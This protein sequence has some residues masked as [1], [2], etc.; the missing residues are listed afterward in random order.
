MLPRAWYERVLQVVCPFVR[1]R[2]FCWPLGEG[3]LLSSFFLRTFVVVFLQNRIRATFVQRD[4]FAL[5]NIFIM[6]P[7]RVSFRPVTLRFQQ[8]AGTSRGIYTERRLWYVELRGNT[9]GRQLFGIGECAPLV[10]LSCDDVPDYEKRL[11]SACRILAATGEIP[12][13]LL[14]NYPSILMGLETAV[15]SYEACLRRGNPFALYDT[16]FSRG[17]EG[18]A[19]NG[20]VWMGSYDEMFA[21][22]EEKLDAG[23]RCVKLKIGAIDFERELD[24]LRTL[25]RRYS[26]QQ[27]EIRVDANGAF[28]PREVRDRLHCLADFELHS[29]EQPI[30]PGLWSEMGRLCRESPLPIALDEE[31]IGVNSIE[32]RRRLLD[33]IQP[34]YIIL[35]PTLHGGFSGAEEWGRLADERGIGHWVT[36]ALE[37]NIG[38]NAIAQ[39]CSVHYQGARE[40]TQGLGTGQLFIDNYE[41]ITLCVEQGLLWTGDKDTRAFLRA[42][43]LFKSEWESAT[44]TMEVITSGSTGSPQLL[45]VEKSRME[46][47]ARRT[48]RFLGLQEGATALLCLPLKYIAGKMMVVRALVGKLRLLCVAPC[49]HPLRHVVVPPDFIALTPMQALASLRTEGERELLE[50]AR[51][52]IIGG[53]AISPEL[54]SAVRTCRGKVYSTYGMTETLSH[55]ALRRLNGEHP[56]EGYTPLEGVALSLTSEECLV[57]N[58]PEVCS[59]RLVTRDR[60]QL[61]ADGT[62]RLLGRIDNVVCS[63]GLKLQLEMLEEK[64]L[65]LPF[66]FMLTAVPDAMLGEALVLLHEPTVIKVEKI[67]RQRL[68]RHEQPRHYFCVPHLPFT[69][70]GK[71][72]RAQAKSMAQRLMEG[73]NAEK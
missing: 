23:F 37:S 52:V 9:T 17:E 69:E 62:F 53:G 63:G 27:L 57:I 51:C 59:E 7:F 60:A 46:A 25:R 43:E 65:G 2:A 54:Q 12:R 32:E 48:L 5:C 18:I 50:S 41:H 14:G 29:I 31:L 24:L 3:K 45:R 61:H 8:P 56:A 35:K 49:S 39:W 28:A 72:A 73:Q 42:V 21:R 33:T 70:T 55:I 20:L 40:R 66:R 16:P 1:Q 68:S 67:C 4:E 36:S 58:A 64:L 44:P 19:I 22:M 38:L 15:L 71:A 6:P 11:E 30:P 10:G 26:A 34:H 13:T 47:S